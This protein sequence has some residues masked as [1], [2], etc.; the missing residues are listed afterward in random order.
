MV[1]NDPFELASLEETE[2]M[3]SSDHNPD[4]IVNKCIKAY[5]QVHPKE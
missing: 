4:D 3:D 5:E 1:L 2:E